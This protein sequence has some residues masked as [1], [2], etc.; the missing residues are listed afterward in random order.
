ME[1]KRIFPLA[2]ALAGAVAFT[3]CSSSTD[4]QPVASATPSGES[5]AP[6]AD[7]ANDRDQALVRV[8]QAVPGEAMDVTVDK[9]PLASDVAYASVTPYREV[10][11]SADDFALK[12][13]GQADGEAIVA[14]NSEGIMSGK[15]YTLVAFPGKGDDRAALQVITDDVSVP[16]D[17]RARVRVIN[18]ASDSGEIDVTAKGGSDTLF[19]DVD[20]R[21]A[22]GYEDV[23]PTMAA[24]DVRSKDGKKVVASPTISLAA[25]RSYTVVLTGKA[26][27]SPELRALVIEDRPVGQAVTN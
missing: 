5:T 19:D 13:A 24:L 17:G 4:N 2:L 21:E 11:A 18:A 16:A 23:D 15:H 27:G 12:T 20:F 1:M 22:T 25:G 7:A 3:A 9:A 10:P 8:V 6:P 26:Q 14:E